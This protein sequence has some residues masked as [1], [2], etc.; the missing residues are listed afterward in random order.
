MVRAVKG[1]IAEKSGIFMSFIMCLIA[2][3]LMTL[4]VTWVSVGVV[5]VLSCRVM[6][7]CS[8]CEI[9]V[10]HVKLVF[11]ALM[12]MCVSMWVWVWVWVWVCIC[13]CVFVCICVGMLMLV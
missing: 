4:A 7:Q 3:Q 5:D 13:A 2:F 11:G 6:F 1:M 12:S 10:C 9:V 8:S